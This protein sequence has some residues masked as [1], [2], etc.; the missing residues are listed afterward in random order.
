MG[1][2]VTVTTGANASDPTVTTGS[3]PLSVHPARAAIANIGM[4]HFKVAPFGW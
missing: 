2:T 3:L 4:S 1:A